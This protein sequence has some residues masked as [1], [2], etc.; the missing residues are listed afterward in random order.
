MSRYRYNHQVDPPAPFAYALVGAPV[1]GGPSLECPVQ[2]DSAADLSV[3]PRRIVERL[4]LEQLGEFDAIGFGGH[5]M[6]IPTFLVR[7]QLRGLAPHVVKVLASPEEPY[8]LLGRDVLNR[9]RV[10]LDGPNLV[11]EIE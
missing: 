10:V 4:Q 2:L 11:L 9:F 6:T 5:L 7:V 3:V 8:V 1:D